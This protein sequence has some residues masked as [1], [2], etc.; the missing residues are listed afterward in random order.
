MSSIALLPV[1]I[2]TSFV[3]DVK[4]QKGLGGALSVVMMIIMVIAILITN[5][6]GGRFQKGAKR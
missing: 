5:Y 3:G 6:I 1:Q 4:M 2:S